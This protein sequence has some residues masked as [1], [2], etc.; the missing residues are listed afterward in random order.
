MVFVSSLDD[1]AS[2]FD[3]LEALFS[4]DGGEFNVPEVPMPPPILMR[5]KYML[6][7]RGENMLTISFRFT[8]EPIIVNLTTLRLGPT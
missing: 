3:S 1:K 8:G 6:L 4:D 5:N 2:S 7:N